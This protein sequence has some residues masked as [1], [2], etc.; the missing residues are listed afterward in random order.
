MTQV[1]QSLFFI[2]VGTNGTGKT[3]LLNKLISNTGRKR[4]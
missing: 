4:L 2:I 3:T 1:R